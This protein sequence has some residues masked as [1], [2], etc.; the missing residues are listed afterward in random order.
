MTTRPSLAARLDAGDR[1]LFERLVIAIDVPVRVRVAW[2]LLTHLG[3]PTA[4]IAAALV[5]LLVPL[6][7][8]RVGARTPAWLAA[9]AL[10]TTHGIVHIAKRRWLRTRPAP[11][12]VGRAHVAVP[13]DFSFPSGHSAAAMSVALAY[14]IAHPALASGFLL[15]AALVGLSRVRLG[16]HYPGDVVAGQAIAIAVT[17]LVHVIG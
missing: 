17:F 1:A 9:A 12:L 10:A 13:D 5:P 11:A 2:R 16:V 8:P 4:T 14:A 6:L 15:L 7:A 3:G